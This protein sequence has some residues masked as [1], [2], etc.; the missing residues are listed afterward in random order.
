VRVTEGAEL[1]VDLDRRPIRASGMLFGHVAAY[2]R[3]RAWQFFFSITELTD[4][5][6]PVFEV[7]LHRVAT[8]TDHRCVVARLLNKS[9]AQRVVPVLGDIWIE[10]YHS[11]S[12][13]PGNQERFKPCPN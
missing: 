3:C 11:P 5:G 7:V 9:D 2:I 12:L 6:R 8:M 4:R 13:P 1:F 10:E